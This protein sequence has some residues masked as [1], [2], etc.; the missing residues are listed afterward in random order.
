MSEF[1]FHVQW[2]IPT[3]IAVIG[4]AL[5][6]NGNKAQVARL[7]NAGAGIVAFALLWGIA[8]YIVD[9]DQEK[10][11][12]GTHETLDAVVAG[13]WDVFQSKLTPTALFTVNGSPI[14]ASTAA[15]DVTEYAR[16]GADYIKLKSAH[17]QNLTLEQVGTV[18]TAHFE[19]LS[20]PGDSFCSLICNADPLKQ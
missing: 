2:W 1:L 4:I 12:N 16:E 10:V 14:R 3:L 11:E 5:F 9:T 20:T 8:S 18:I 7:R 15:E 19:I 17:I 13:K 6:L